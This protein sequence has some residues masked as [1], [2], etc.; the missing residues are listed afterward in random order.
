M[1]PY[2][3]KMRTPIKKKKKNEDRSTSKFSCSFLLP[4]SS[5]A[6]GIPYLPFSQ[7][8]TALSLSL[9]D[10]VFYSTVLSFLVLINDLVFASYHFSPIHVC[11]RDI[12]VQLYE[13]QMR[14]YNPCKPS[15]T[16]WLFGFLFLFLVF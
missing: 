13:R 15:I 8:S 2:E 7:P 14:R 6:A 10:F 12:N 4:P 9:S 3:I 1:F 5:N 16:N 11:G